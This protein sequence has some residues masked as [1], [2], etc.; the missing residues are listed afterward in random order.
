MNVVYRN[1]PRAAAATVDGLAAFGVATE[2]RGATLTA[3]PAGHIV[4]AIFIDNIANKT[5]R[6]IKAKVES[7]FG[8]D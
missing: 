6:C 1:T 3:W 8:A 5:L 2:F 4:G 7:E